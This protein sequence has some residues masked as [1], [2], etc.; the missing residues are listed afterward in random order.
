MSSCADCFWNSW[1]TLA[2]FAGAI[3]WEDKQGNDYYH[4]S[5]KHKSLKKFNNARKASN[6][7]Q[8]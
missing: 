3:C 2:C 5:H 1:I 4:S 6:T 7:L 8:I